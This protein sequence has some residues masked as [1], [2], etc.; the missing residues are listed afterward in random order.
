MTLAGKMNMTR[1]FILTDRAVANP[2]QNMVVT[3]V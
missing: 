1:A 2:D 3:D